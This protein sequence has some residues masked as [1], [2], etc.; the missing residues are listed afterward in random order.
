MSM[1]PYESPKSEA[2]PRP[3]SSAERAA[4]KRSIRISL[5]IMLVPA[6]YNSICFSFPDAPNRSELPI[7]NVYRTINGIGFV[8]IV[9]AIWFLGLAALEFVTGGLHAIFSRNSKLHDWKTSLYVVVR[10]A[11]VFALCGAVL[12]A[13]WVAAFYQLGIGF[14]TVSLPIGI[15]A[16]L[17]AAGLYIPLFYRW[18]KVE[19]AGMSL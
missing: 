18:Y 12:W 4:A 10:R 1:N 5:A 7:H 17:L 14:Y 13:I 11:P 2:T 15:A 16:H 9:I 3:P 19:R 6:I 8:A